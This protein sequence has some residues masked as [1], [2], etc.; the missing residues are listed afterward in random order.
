[1]CTIAF[2]MVCT[3]RLVHVF[4][5]HHPVLVSIS[6]PLTMDVHDIEVLISYEVSTSALGRIEFADRVAALK[7]KAAK[8][9]ERDPACGSW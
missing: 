1:M 9:R 8:R 3:M 7:R 5:G 2:V 4:K 6:M